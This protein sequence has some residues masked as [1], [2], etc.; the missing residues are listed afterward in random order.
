MVNFFGF[1]VYLF[2]LFM[3]KIISQKSSEVFCLS[4]ILYSVWVPFGLSLDPAKK[5]NLQVKL[6]TI[7]QT[8]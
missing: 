8:D 1:P 2:A 5:W 3:Y 7:Q 4:L 6:K